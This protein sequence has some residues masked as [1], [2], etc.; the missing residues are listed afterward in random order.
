MFAALGRFSYRRRW[1]VL[2]AWVGAF[3]LSVA[4]LPTLTSHLKGGGFANPDSSSEKA[5]A[6]IDKKLGTGTTVLEVVFTSDKLKATSAEFKKQ[7][8]RALEKITPGAV[9]DLEQV[10]TYETSG[11][12]Q[13][14]SKDGK[15]S[16]AVLMFGAS[17]YDVQASVAQIRAALQATDLRAY[18]TGEP[19]VN[20]DIVAA[21]WHD[22]RIA[23]SYA[24]PIAL[25]AL[26]VVF[27]TV[28]AA[29]LPVLG[30]GMAVAVTLGSLY[31]LAQVTD[32]SIFSM[33]VASL[34][35][36]AIGI[37]YAL[38]MV[39]RFREELE[40]RQT[41][42]RAVEATVARAGRSVFFSGL[43]VAVGILGLVFFPFAAMRS[44]GVAGAL[45]V[46]FCVA[47][48]LTLL[49][50][51][52]G[53]FGPR[54]NSLRI[55]RVPTGPSRFW[56]WWSRWVVRAPWAAIILGVALIALVSSPVV[57]MK[58]QM[59]TATVLPPSA[60]SRKGYELLLREFDMGSL[61][62]IQV[63]VT[64]ND[65]GSPLAAARLPALYNYG[66]LL[67]RQEG[68]QRVDSVATL[69]GVTSPLTLMMFWQVAGPALESGQPVEIGSFKLS[70]AQTAQLKQLVQTT[71]APGI[72]VYRVVP[73]ADPSS[74]EASDLV[75]RLRE[76]PAPQGAQVSI[77]GDGA[78]RL[79]FFE[80]LYKRFP[81]VAGVVLA[82]SFVILLLLTNSLLIPLVS[83]AV[84]ACTIAMSYGIIVFI[85]QHGHFER[86]LAFTGNGAV[87][88]IMPVI[89]FCTLFGITMD[90]QVFLVS[91][92]HECWHDTHDSRLSVTCG[93]TQSGRVIVS[94]ALLVVVV[95]GSFAFTSIS[96]T[97]T[98][99]IGV[100]FAVLLDILLVRMLLVPG[101]MV[102]F[103]RAAW[104]MPRR[105]RVRLPELGEE[106][107]PQARG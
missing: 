84:N 57:H 102:L 26:L 76:L 43:A 81:L 21:S 91:R 9:P 23:E 20:A 67:A 56:S 17:K 74:A 73:E 62:P 65:G 96:M 70:A 51:L 55:V 61:S 99:G 15:S 25:L 10:L 11:N 5:V 60:E 24:I 36:L 13:L 59:P 47:A 28:A 93:L 37:D 40:A 7:E 22:L 78:S 35:G 104:W 46:V 72:V 89:M 83:L 6:L 30:G 68:V 54:I 98:L 44:I 97:K 16:V 12:E 95:A 64:F 71:V 8:S 3:L 34:L 79:D 103:G 45:V 106:P 27:G 88:A 31:L 63:A 52:L 32:V 18:V 90:Y 101:L 53:I 87:D 105:L 77:A 94:A 58:M 29:A 41:V 75:K 80:G 50:A 69:P 85:F 86:L 4:C 92:M 38:F 82:A 19:A 66:Q 49:P 2:G 48:A 14:I 33:N 39:A 1:W 42:G 100:A 107:E